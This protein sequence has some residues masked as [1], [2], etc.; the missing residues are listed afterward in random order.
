MLSTTVTAN[1]SDFQVALLESIRKDPVKLYSQFRGLSQR[2]GGMKRV[3]KVNNRAYRIVQKRYAGGTLQKINPDGGSLGTGSGPSASE[4]YGGFFYGTFGIELTDKLMSQTDTVGSGTNGGAMMNAFTESVGEAMQT[5]V[6]HM[7]R[8]LFGSGNGLL[9]E[10]ASATGSWSGGTTY[11]FNGASDYVGCNWLIPGMA[12][13]LIASNLTTW[14]PQIGTRANHPYIVDNIDW[15]TKTV[16]LIGSPTTPATGDRLTVVGISSTAGASGGGLFGSA[17][18]GPAAPA[19]GAN[20][21]WPLNQAA[22]GDSW[23]HGIQYANN[24]DGASYYLGVQRSTRPQLLPQSVNAA[25]S[26]WSPFHT[27]DLRDKLIESAGPDALTGLVG[28]VH[29]VQRKQTQAT[30]L[31]ITTAPITMGGQDVKDPVPTTGPDGL[32]PF[33]WGDVNHEIYPQQPRNRV[34][35]VNWSLWETAADFEG[36]RP[37]M[38]GGQPSFR[39]IDVAT[40]GQ[41]TRQQWMWEFSRDYICVDPWR[42]GYIYNLAIPTTS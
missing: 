36:P 38:T 27:H 10:G 14:K 40:G 42:Q 6:M 5:L 4:M 35:Y 18:W 33:V 37:I 8:Y 11:T 41:T 19:V 30:G 13:Y 34:D 16:Y 22:S 29:M 1:L 12:V 23:I 17:G 24:N 25:A 39:I 2:V 3:T 9:T 7:D 26:Y 28:I 15:G 31:S 21:D 20:G 32:K